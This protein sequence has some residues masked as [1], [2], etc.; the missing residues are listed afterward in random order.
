MTTAAVLT[1]TATVNSSSR[2]LEVTSGAM[3]INAHAG[4]I[5]RIT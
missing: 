4:R 3:T 1:G 5:V 2:I